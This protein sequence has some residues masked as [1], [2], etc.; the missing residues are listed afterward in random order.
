MA[1]AGNSEDNA[2]D[3]QQLES[4]V[5]S[6]RKSSRELPSLV[7]GRVPEACWGLHAPRDKEDS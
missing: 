4:D 1:R 2:G 3:G 7:A 5:V 6:A